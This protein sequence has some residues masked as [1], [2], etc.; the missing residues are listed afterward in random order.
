M[1]IMQ[2]HPQFLEIY[3]AFFNIN[4]T[5]KQ[6]VI[7][8]QLAEKTL[9]DKINDFNYKNIDKNIRQDD[10]LIAAYQLINGLHALHKNDLAHRDIKP[11]NILILN[12]KYILADFDISGRIIRDDNLNTIINKNLGLDC[13]LEYQSPEFLKERDR[14][15]ELHGK[16]R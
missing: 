5:Q 1:K 4:E 16:A 11:S 9:F 12:E 3:G 13:T 15:T 2:N 10:A 7:V 14:I 8:M 6:F